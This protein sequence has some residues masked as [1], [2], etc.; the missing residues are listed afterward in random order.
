MQGTGIN[1]Y[2]H[3][4]AVI[5]GGNTAN[6]VPG[7]CKKTPKSLTYRIEGSQIVVCNHWHKIVVVWR[8]L[9]HQKF[10]DPREKGFREKNEIFIFK[11]DGLQN[12]SSDVVRELARQRT[13]SA[14]ELYGRQLRKKAIRTYDIDFIMATASTQLDAPTICETRPTWRPTPAYLLLLEMLLQLVPNSECI[15]AAAEVRAPHT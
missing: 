13:V 11:F 6:G 2:E 9:A 14:S 5:L 15:M 10:R 12:Q 8:A 3:V 7:A 4:A 1:T